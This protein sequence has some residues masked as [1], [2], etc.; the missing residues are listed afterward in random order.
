M[1]G[2]VGVCFYGWQKTFVDDV[3]QDIYSL[4]KSGRVLMSHLRIDVSCL[5]YRYTGGLLLMLW[6]LSQYLII[7]GLNELP[8]TL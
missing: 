3:V 5:E 8:Y 4:L 6:I 1:G 2:F 7:L